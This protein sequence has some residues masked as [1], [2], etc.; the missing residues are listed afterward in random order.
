MNIAVIAGFLILS[1]LLLIL[2]KRKGADFKRLIIA[3][4]FLA[5]LPAAYFAR[6]S[7]AP[8]AAV[9]Q[10][11]PFYKLLRISEFGYQSFLFDLLLYALPFLPAGLL[12]PI[13]FPG[14]GIFLSLLSGGAAAFFM[15]LPYLFAGKLFVSDEIVYAALGIAAGTAISI[16]LMHVF[17]NRPLFKR[18]GILPPFKSRLRAGIIT[19]AAIYFGVALTMIVDFGEAYG[20]LQLFS[21][22]TPLPSDI[23]LS[24]EL[25]FDSQKAAVYEAAG[26]DALARG[27]ETANRLG[28]TTEVQYIEDTYVFAQEGYILRYSPNGSWTYTSPA[29]PEGEAPSAE[30]AEKLARAFFEEN[31][32]LPEL[33]ELNDL[34]VKTNADKIPEFSED[35]G[36]TREQYDELVKIYEQPAGY[37]LYFATLAE[38][39]PIIGANEI[40]VSVRE[41]GTLTEIRKFDADLSKKANTRIISQKDAYDRLME[42]KGA[43]TLFSPAKSA[44]FYGCEL[45]YMVNSAQGYYL[46]VWRFMAKAVLEDGTETEFEAYVPAMK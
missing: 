40:M 33:G 43:Y 3:A 19:L 14:K 8:A 31:Q 39:C 13:A 21:S 38:G 20:E 23:T 35:L 11:V 37:D 28:I 25:S 7:L 2:L 46:P 16:I 42:G 34:A 15:D 18:L 4:I 9:S 12:F 26:S 32:V 6:K 10:Y 44:D 36:L 41:G 24:A 29:A 5:L 30:D 17:R 22:D 45:S 1:A 27:T